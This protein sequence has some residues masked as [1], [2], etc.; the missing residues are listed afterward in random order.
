[1]ED[2]QPDDR[3][4]I[5]DFLRWYGS[6]EAHTLGC[7][8]SG[9]D[10][11]RKYLPYVKLER[12]LSKR[13]IKEILEALFDNQERQVPD[14]ASVRKNYLRPFAIL[15]WIGSGRMIS[16]FSQHKSLRDDKLP[17]HTKPLGFPSSTKCN[18]FE[19]FSQKQ[20]EFCAVKFEYNTICRLAADEIIPIIDKVDIGGGGSAFVYKITVDG[21]YDDLVP[22]ND[23]NSVFTE[24]LLTPNLASLTE[25]RNLRINPRTRMF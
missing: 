5:Q 16:H 19:L 1:M 15:L 21:D 13:K 24:I 6:Q 25:D 2:S 17:F 10:L 9:N 7:G 22:P 18:L 14:A 8:G 12:R 23:A 11:N 4:V 3:Q 20:W